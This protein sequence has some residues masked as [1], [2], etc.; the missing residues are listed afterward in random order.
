MKFTRELTWRAIYDICPDLAILREHGI[1]LSMPESL[2]MAATH[3]FINDLGG[4]DLAYPC[5]VIRTA[6]KEL[7]GE[8]KIEFGDVSE[9]WM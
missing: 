4:I 1:Q 8:G 5:Y 6:L 9:Y 7:G 3:A 2:S